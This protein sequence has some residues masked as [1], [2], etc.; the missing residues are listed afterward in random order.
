MSPPYV[1]TIREEILYEYAKLTSRS[2]Y[3]T[4]ENGMCPYC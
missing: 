1:N 4:L 2:A 3:G